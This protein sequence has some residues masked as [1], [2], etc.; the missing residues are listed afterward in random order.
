[1]YTI[2]Y[3]KVTR[4]LNWAPSLLLMAMLFLA[5]TAW[6]G[7]ISGVVTDQATDEPL[8]GANVQIDNLDMGTHTDRDGR[9]AL[10]NVPAGQY[11]ISASYIGY[12]VTKN[13]TDVGAETV[14]NFSLKPTVL[15]GQDVVITGSRAMEGRTPVAFSNMDRRDIEVINQGQDIPMLLD[16][17]PNLYSYSESGN[18]IG[19]SHLKIRGFN[20]QRVNV[21]INNIPLNDPEDHQVYWVDLPDFAESVQD[22]QV[23]RGAGNAM[24]GLSGFGG[25]VNILTENFNTERGLSI[26]TGYGDFDT[27]KYTV[28]FRSGLINNTYAVYGRYSRVLS[29]GYRHDSGIDAWAYFIGAARYDRN[30]TTRINIFSG[31]FTLEAAWDA[32]AEASLEEDHRANPTHYHPNVLTTD[33][34]NQPHYQLHHEWRLADDKTLHNS[35]FYVQGRGYYET[36]KAGEDLV[37]HGYRYYEDSSG[38]QITETDIVRQKWVDKDHAGWIPRLELQHADNRGNLTVGGEVNTFR[39]EHWGQITWASNLPP[40]AEPN[41]RYYEY[42][43]GKWWV[44]AYVHENFALTPDL[45]LLGELQ[46]QHKN[47][48]MEQK[49]A[50]NFDGSELNYYEVDYTFFNPKLG[51]NYNV[52][53]RLNVFGNVSIGN[54]EPTDA[55]LFDTWQGADDFGVDPLFAEADTVYHADGSVKYIEWDEPLTEHETVYNYELGLGYQ[56]ENW[57]AKLNLYYMDYRNEIVPYGQVVD[58]GRVIRGNADRTVHQGVELSLSREF[59][60]GLKLDANVAYSQNEFKEFTQ[61]SWDGTPT[62]LDGNTIALFPSLVANIRATA[63]WPVPVLGDMTGS[64]HVQHVGQQY[65][66][67]TENDERT[68]DPYSVV[69]LTLAY[70]MR[71]VPGFQQMKFQ[72]WVNNLLDERYETSGYYDDWAGS[73]FYYPAA[74]RNFYGSVTVEF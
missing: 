68:I 57:Q 74:G 5:P 34:F 61:Y 58:D 65:L 44:T 73:N 66:D 60:P 6:C 18:G 13:K 12:E 70:P 11:T 64:L 15:P 41:K 9:Y 3:S 27:R 32:V 20:Q 4:R 36:F 21:M 71:L 56:H 42:D 62:S 22:I 17:T 40:G 48:T 35:L 30:M 50:G 33:N 45:L 46:V 39:S 26:S 49:P 28:N 24:Y 52:S 8:I 53:A 43:G 51:L 7:Q 59:Q 47:R 29:D 55:D 23:Q 63:Q 1:M 2:L 38:Q 67:N 25:S 14:L 10:T 72:F 37:D 19:Y 16:E 54:R 69:N 31:P